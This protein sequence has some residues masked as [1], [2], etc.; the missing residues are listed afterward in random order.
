ME[1]ALKELRGE[2]KG[3]YSSFVLELNSL[4]DKWGSIKDTFVDLKGQ[5]TRKLETEF[6]AI[7][8][9]ILAN[10]DMIHRGVRRLKLE[11]A[12]VQDINL[13]LDQAKVSVAQHCFLLRTMKGS[14]YL[15]GFF[16]S[17]SIDVL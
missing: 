3:P 1:K 15:K 17:P 6:E 14:E 8:G 10:L 11:S 13:L 12:D 7:Q 9:Q 5:P 4:K 16:F 2:E